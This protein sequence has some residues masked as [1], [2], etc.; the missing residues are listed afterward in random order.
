M[1]QTAPEQTTDPD[2]SLPTGWIVRRLKAVLKEPLKYGANEAA[3]SDDPDNPRF[4]RITDIADDGGLKADTFRSLP[5]SI[6]QPYLLEEGDLLLARSGA[7]VGK[8]VM[9]TQS[10][11][12]CCFAGYLIRA[13]PDRRKILPEYLRYFS[14]SKLYW[15]HIATEQI[16]ATIQNVSAD[17]YANLPVPMPKVAKQR[18]VVDFLDREIAK[19]DALIG[20]QRKLTATLR[21]D[22][23]ACISHAVTQGLDPK[24]EMR[25]S[26]LDW[27][28]VAPADWPLV[29]LKSVVSF[30]EG[31]G[32]MAVDFREE[33]VPLLRVASVRNAWA[34]LNGC[35]YLDPE[36]VRT[37]WARF[38]VEVGDLLISASASMGTVAEVGPDVEGAIPYTGI[39][40]VLVG[41]EV[42]RDFIRWYLM[43]GPFN[44]QIELMRQGSTIQHY[45][46][47][48][49]SRMK[50]HVPP[51]HEQGE[52]AA[53]IGTRC[54]QIDDL[55]AKADQVIESLREFRSALITNAVTGKIDV[56]DAH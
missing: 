17:R 30:Q 12:P 11:G 16:Q 1:N 55:I 43:S 35:N 34:S 39:I 2:L 24:A 45:G 20:K 28:D 40:R 4:V 29:P 51:I 25:E 27:V 52:I 14:E 49:L 36:K 41:P 38:R 50:L 21:E 31:P 26:G 32:I 9:Y 19:I 47:T 53:F 23:I 48:H 42:K 3:D 22:R 7:T 6:A 54:G 10:W 8:S 18:L 33:G 5:M 56:L 46:P 15:Q 37:A 44:T 13:R